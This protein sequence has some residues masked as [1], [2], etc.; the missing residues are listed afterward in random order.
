MPMFWRSR[1]EKLNDEQDDGPSFSS[2]PALAQPP[3][4]P[5]AQP[6]AAAP[7]PA[8]PT[9][10]C[11]E[12]KAT[13]TCRHLPPPMPADLAAPQA[14][15][16]AAASGGAASPELPGGE[17]PGDAEK[18]KKKKHKKHAEQDALEG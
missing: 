14:P 8:G 3:P 16:P 15:P 2:S 1:A 9:C 4:Q 12:F 17:P 18:K 13:G 5:L 10:S 6:P 11:K 7:A